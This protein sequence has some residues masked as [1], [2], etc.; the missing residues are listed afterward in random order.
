MKEKIALLY[1]GG[2]DSTW[3]YY[4]ILRKIDDFDQ[5]TLV[6]FNRFN[7]PLKKA[8]NLY[9]I[10]KN[11]WGD[12]TSTLE[13]L[14]VPE[15][16]HKQTEYVISNLSARFDR[17]VW[18]INKYPT[19]T[20]IRPKSI[21]YTVTDHTNALEKYPKLSIPLINTEKDEIIKKFYEHEIE[22]ILPLTHS[23]GS[24]TD[25]PC[26]ICFNCKERIWAYNKIGKTLDMG[27]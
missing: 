27:I 13:I 18:G 7:K 20:S 23:C 1:S 16:G 3:L 25:K 12:K 11:M 21:L 5:L 24:D 6:L 19:D 14:D 15:L 22:E 26:G 2:I 10:L 9:S 17:V 8:I 4:D